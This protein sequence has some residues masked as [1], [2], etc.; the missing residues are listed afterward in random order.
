M[1]LVGHHL[2]GAINHV[3]CRWYTTLSSARKAEQLG[4][5]RVMIVW[6]FSTFYLNR[7]LRRPRRDIF[8]AAEGKAPDQVT[9][10]DPSDTQPN[11]EIYSSTFR[12][13]KKKWVCYEQVTL[14]DQIG[15]GIP[16]G[17]DS[18]HRV[19]LLSQS[20]TLHVWCHALIVADLNSSQCKWAHLCKSVWL[21]LAVKGRGVGHFVLGPFRLSSSH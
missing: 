18:A 14:M 3:T 9:E 5:L 4:L 20:L 17:S 12:C 11:V 21:T 10:P 19:P 15:L 7:W 1:R 16:A 6:F 13:Q 8:M 2:A